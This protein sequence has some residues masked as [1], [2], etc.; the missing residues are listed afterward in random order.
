VAFETPKVRSVGAPGEEEVLG[1][2]VPVD[3]SGGVRFRE[4]LACL[5]HVVGRQ[6]FG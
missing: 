6:L 3:D 1:F 4:W 5:Q 2:E